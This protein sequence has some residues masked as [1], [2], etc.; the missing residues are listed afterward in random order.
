[1]KLAIMQPY[2]FPYIG[3]FQLIGSVDAFVVYDNIKY[4][5]KGWINRNRFLLNGSD[6]VFSLP[7]KKDSD[8]LDIKEREVSEAFDRQQFTGQITNAYRKAPHLPAVLGLL[9]ETLAFEDRNLFAFLH[10]SIITTCARLGITTRIVTSSQIDCDH[11][12]KA[13]ERVIAIC[14][15]MGA[16]Q[17]INSIGG[18][19]L[20]SK[21][22]F[23]TNGIEL[24][25]L[26]SRPIDYRQFSDP[27]VPWLSILD[28][29]A[30]NPLETI[31]G[32]ISSGYDLV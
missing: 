24:S 29:M 1:M 28:V 10:H 27:F 9:E 21:E 14:K 2:W 22:Q 30:F 19:E 32:F 7:L 12:L 20:Y 17:Y 4:T 13:E 15:A 6:A 31:N 3:Y 8:A 26:K 18:Q 5:K 16:T 23:S 11:G 25:F